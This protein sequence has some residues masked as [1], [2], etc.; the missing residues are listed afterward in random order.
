M[1]IANAFRGFLRGETRQSR[2][3]EAVRF[4]RRY[5][6]GTRPVTH[7]RLHGA[8]VEAVPAFLEA[9]GLENEKD[10]VVAPTDADPSIAK[11]VWIED[12]RGGEFAK[13]CAAQAM[14]TQ[15]GLNVCERAY[16]AVVRKESDD[17]IVACFGE[18][19]DESEEPTHPAPVNTL[20]EQIAAMSADI[21]SRTRAYLADPDVKKNLSPNES[22]L[23][24][25]LKSVTADTP[26]NNWKLIPPLFV[27]EFFVRRVLGLADLID[28]GPGDMIFNAM[29]G[30]HAVVRPF[31]YGQKC[32]LPHLFDAPLFETLGCEIGEDPMRGYVSNSRE[33][34]AKAGPCNGVAVIGNSSFMFD[35]KLCADKLS[36]AQYVVNNRLGFWKYLSRLYQSAFGPLVKAELMTLSRIGIRN[37]SNAYVHHFQISDNCEPTKSHVNRIDSGLTALVMYGV[38]LSFDN[39][40]Q[41]GLIPDNLPGAEIEVSD[42]APTPPDFAETRVTKEEFPAE[43]FAMTHIQYPEDHGTADPESR[44]EEFLKRFRPDAAALNRSVM[45]PLCRGDAAAFVPTEDDGNT[46]FNAMNSF[47]SCVIASLKDLPTFADARFI[48]RKGLAKGDVLRDAVIA[49]VYSGVSTDLAPEDCDASQGVFPKLPS[50]KLYVDEPFGDDTVISDGAH[51]RF[52][53]LIDAIRADPTVQLRMAKRS[54]GK[55][56]CYHLIVETNL[57]MG[58]LLDAPDDDRE[59]FMNRMNRIATW[60]LALR[61]TDP[62]RV[63]SGQPVKD[64]MGVVNKVVQTLGIDNVK[65]EKAFTGSRVT[66]FPFDSGA[67]IANYVHAGWRADAAGRLYLVFDLRGDGAQLARMA[68]RTLA[69]L[70]AANAELAQVAW[71][72]ENAATTVYAE[73]RY[74]SEYVEEV[75][76]KALDRVNPIYATHHVSVPFGSFVPMVGPHMSG[77]GYDTYPDRNW[78][79]ANSAGTFNPGWDVRMS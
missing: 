59:C 2:R 47:T 73:N 41:E 27:I 64:P 12:G 58:V 30:Y 74:D 66:Q 34:F 35:C 31:V 53:A 18:T 76:R 68:W 61:Y 6:D 45:E 39:M 10:F 69:G 7:Y 50:W 54:A 14:M 79:T 40:V 22:I 46:K 21:M 78:F 38:V 25:A 43:W 24:D 77:V 17:A 56:R 3:L 4:V 15:D 60:S 65:A 57:P 36:A 5:S 51:G 28:D 33:D 52:G 71:T 23:F 26:H 44:D 29:T 55:L 48:P 19:S 75:I 67:F 13:A 49:G 11:L 42:S 8:S 1:N 9:A 72:P 32:P 62:F 16:A 20:T 70:P 63:L 37:S